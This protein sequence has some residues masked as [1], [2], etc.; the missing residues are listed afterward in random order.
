MFFVLYE[1]VY[2]FLHMNHTCKFEQDNN[3][4]ASNSSVPAT[5]KGQKGQW[6]YLLDVWR[7]ET[8]FDTPS[9]SSVYRVRSR[10]HELTFVYSCLSDRGPGTSPRFVQYRRR[11]CHNR[12]P[13]NAGPSRPTNS[14]DIAT[15]SATHLSYECSCWAR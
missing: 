2:F 14:C 15:R 11:F 5:M 3:C 12:S 4:S 7:Y 9:G 8:S 6:I 13:L 1:R 10:R